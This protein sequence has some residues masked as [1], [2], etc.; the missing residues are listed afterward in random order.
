[1]EPFTQN[2]QNANFGPKDIAAKYALHLGCSA[3]TTLGCHCEPQSGVVMLTL[4]IARKISKRTDVA[5][6]S[7]ALRGMPRRCGGCLMVSLDCRVAALLAMTRWGREWA[8]WFRPSFRIY[9]HNA[10]IASPLGRGNPVGLVAEY[11]DDAVI[12][13]CVRR[14]AV[15]GLLSSSR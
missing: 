14:I 12:A 7:H 1:M 8:G 4:V 15:S 6:Q 11:P 5:I 13:L 9:S 3:D 10:V 2:A